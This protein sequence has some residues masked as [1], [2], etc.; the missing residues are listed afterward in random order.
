MLL[1]LEAAALKYNGL[2]A[3]K[4]YIPF[5]RGRLVVFRFV[6]RDTNNVEP[7]FSIE[8]CRCDRYTN[9]YSSYWSKQNT[10]E[11]YFKK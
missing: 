2:V 1:S 8:K 3:A 5:Y 7:R 9:F 11:N 6:A 4:I 10:E